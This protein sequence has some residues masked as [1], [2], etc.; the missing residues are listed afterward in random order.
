MFVIFAASGLVYG[1][2]SG[3]FAKPADVVP[4]MVKAMADMILCCTVFKLF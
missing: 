1:F 3:K 2:K 4:A